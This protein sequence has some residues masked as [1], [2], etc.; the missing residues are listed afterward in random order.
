MPAHGYVEENGSTTILAAKMSAG[1]APEVNL[2][3]CVTHT[4]LPSSNKT[5]HSGIETQ[6]KHHQ[7]SE[8]GLDLSVV[9]PRKDYVVQKFFLKKQDARS[10]SGKTKNGCELTFAPGPSCHG[11]FDILMN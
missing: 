9:N 5:A 10:H 3:E 1:V 2:R 11:P 6:R 4:P 7:K 8:T